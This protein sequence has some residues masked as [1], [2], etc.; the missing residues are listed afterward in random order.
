MATCKTKLTHAEIIQIFRD[1][2]MAEENMNI[3]LQAYDILNNAIVSNDKLNICVMNNCRANHD[4]RE[5]LAN[6]HLVDNLDEMIKHGGSIQPKDKNKIAY[7]KEAAN[8]KYEET[9]QISHLVFWGLATREEELDAD[10]NSIGTKYHITPLGINF[11]K[12][13]ARIPI[14]IT[15]LDGEVIDRSMKYTVSV[16][17]LRYERAARVRFRKNHGKK[18][19]PLD[20]RALSIDG[21]EFFSISEFLEYLNS[22]DKNDRIY[23]E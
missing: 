18:Y 10:N 21:R 5:Y 17:D 15:V 8:S 22:K 23:G 4:K 13:L 1:G 6:K 16:D 7:S 2:G 19:I 9:R 14:K 12:G 11:V 20:N 3:A